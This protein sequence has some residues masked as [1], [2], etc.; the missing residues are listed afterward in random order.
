MFYFVKISVK[1]ETPNISDDYQKVMNSLKELGQMQKSSSCSPSVSLSAF[2]NTKPT[3]VVPRSNSKPISTPSTT[4][5]S[6]HNYNC[7][8]I[9]KIN[10]DPKLSYSNQN[11][12]LNKYH[13]IPSST[14]THIDEYKRSNHVTYNCPSAPTST[15]T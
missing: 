12:Y 11:Q 1:T 6:G 15:K 10:S 7:S 5:S 13:Q 4:K 14:I 9:T 2:T 8:T 3:T